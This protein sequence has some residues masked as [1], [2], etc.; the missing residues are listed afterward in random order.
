MHRIAR[1][2]GVL[3]FMSTI[4]LPGRAPAEEP[5]RAPLAT[6]ASTNA[7]GYALMQ[8]H[9][10]PE[11]AEVLERAVAVNPRNKVAWANLGACRMT[12]YECGQAGAA[13]ADQAL[14]AYQKAA[15]IDPAYHADEL[16]QAQAYADREHHWAEA[17]KAREGQSAQV[18]AANGLFREYGFEGDQAET[19]GNFTLAMANY[20]RAKEVAATDKGRSAAENWMGLLFL[21]QRKPQ[22]AVDHLRTA[23][24]LDAANKYAWNN[25]GAALRL[26]YESTGDRK[27]LAEAAAAFK[28]TG[29]LDPEYQKDNRTWADAAIAAAGPS[30]SG[31]QAAVPAADPTPPQPAQPAL[32]AQTASVAPATPAAD[33]SAEAPKPAQPVAAQSQTAKSY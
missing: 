26:Q 6:A 9:R 15:A 7:E 30:R 32:A 8:A 17:A 23:T 25:L 21:K 24:T 5:A 33:A 28:K 31:T 20:Q 4:A 14:V 3:G 27:V 11:A 22:E 13:A 1:I 19:D 18:P 10:Y 29:A 16:K 12:L 2:A